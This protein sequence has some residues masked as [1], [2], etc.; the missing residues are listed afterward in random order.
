M[1]RPRLRIAL[2]VLAAAA[3]GCDDGLPT[4]P[5]ATLPDAAGPSAAV[6]AYAGRIRIG[7]VPAASS[8]KV[9]AT[10][11]YEVREKGTNTLLLSGAA[12]EVVTVTRGTAAVSVTSRR[13]QVVCTASTTDRDQRLA[14]G[15][16]A[17]FPTAAE[18]VSTA[19]C[20]RVYVGERP[21]PIDT[22]AE[23]VYKN[24]VIAAGQATSAALWKTVTLSQN[25]PRYITTR[26]SGAQAL[27][28]EPPVVRPLSGQVLIAGATY[29]GTAEVRQNSAGTL[30]GINELPMEEY[31]YGVVPRELGPVTYPEIE[32]QK[33]QAVAA[34]TYAHANLG[35]HWSNGYDMGAT[36]ADQVYGGYAAEHPTSNS[37]VNATAG[38]VATYGGAMI[39]GL[40]Y[41]TSGGRTA[42]S[43]DVFSATV[44]YL[45]GVWDAPAGQEL[46]GT[47]A[48]LADLRNPSWTGAYGGFHSLHRWNYRW[49]NAQISCVVGDFANKP[50]GKVN[51]INILARSATGR[52]TQ[53]E[54]VTDAGTFVD[55]KTAIRSSLQYINSSG[56]PTLLPSTLFVVER[57]TDAAGVQTGFAVYGGGNGHGAGMAQTGAVGMARAGRTYDQILKAYYTGIVL[58]QKVGTRRDGVAPATTSGTTD[59]Y[60]CTSA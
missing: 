47:T 17:G 4:N 55:S 49:T 58:E 38:I 22:A 36:V 9:G 28:V 50:V 41:A 53:I 24:Q 23:R 20:W 26:T 40:F 21:L 16:A 45:R 1:H 2:L 60:D 30:A 27:S 43:E 19:S 37:A 54:Y 3:A 13:L 56:V 42:N 7:V 57:T 12:N 44:P 25:Q 52:V 51:A 11:A 31:L 35:K 29:R 48:L 10:G 59:P 15:T 33:A 39:D 8:V 5:T 18:F 34:R 14:A 32:A 6:E 46:S